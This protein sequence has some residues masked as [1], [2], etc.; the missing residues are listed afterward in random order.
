[1]LIDAMNKA[2]ET[3]GRPFEMLNETIIKAL[4]AGDKMTTQRKTI[5]VTNGEYKDRVFDAVIGK[6]VAFVE[7][8]DTIEAIPEGSFQLFTAIGGIPEAFDAGDTMFVPPI[9]E[10]VIPLDIAG[11]AMKRMWAPSVL[12]M[13]TTP[14]IDLMKED[15]EARGMLEDWPNPGHPDDPEGVDNV[16]DNVDK[17]AEDPRTIAMSDDNDRLRAKIKGLKIRSKRQGETNDRLAKRLDIQEKTI[18]EVDRDMEATIKDN[19]R[20]KEKNGELIDKLNKADETVCDQMKRIQALETELAEIRALN[21]H[22]VNE[23]E[24]G[25]QY[26]TGIKRTVEELHEALRAKNKDLEL[27]QLQE[28]RLLIQLERANNVI[29]VLTKKTTF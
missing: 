7:I 16:G 5:I 9:R 1:M 17:W 29:D 22:H 23:I 6:D 3:I 26:R 12:K 10:A 8:G 24:K 27:Y 2:L 25:N 28:K 21:N 14:A 20:L 11:E 19:N 13:A 18:K 4:R 15:L